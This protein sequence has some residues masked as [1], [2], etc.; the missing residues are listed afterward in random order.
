MVYF[1]ALRFYALFIGACL[2]A[3]E[4]VPCSVDSVDPKY[5]FCDIETDRPDG[6]HAWIPPAPGHPIGDRSI[7]FKWK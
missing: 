2:A 1:I 5:R 6:R 3:N 7:P 4:H